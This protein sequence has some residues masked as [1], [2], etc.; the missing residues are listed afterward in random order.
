MIRYRSIGGGNRAWAVD[1]WSE[2]Q[3]LPL[4]KVQDGDTL[5]YGDGRVSLTRRNSRWRPDE[6]HLWGRNDTPEGTPFSNGGTVDAEGVWTISSAPGGYLPPPNYGWL[7]VLAIVAP[8]SAG[9]SWGMRDSLMADRPSFVGIRAVVLTGTATSITAT[10]NDSIYGGAS[11][12]YG[13]ESPNDVIYYG[14]GIVVPGGAGGL[15]EDT[16]A[17]SA[18]ESLWR[19]AATDY[20]VVPYDITDPTQAPITIWGGTEHDSRST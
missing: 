12:A 20:N 2:W 18:G 6:E 16:V 9:F 8:A 14:Q 5:W 1:T 3:S 15:G 10:N 11:V 13:D 17:G 4:A 19:P 7:D